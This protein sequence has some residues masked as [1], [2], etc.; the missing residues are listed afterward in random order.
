[1]GREGQL[2]CE[3]CQADAP[4]TKLFIVFGT[5]SI[6]GASVKQQ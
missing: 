2:A 1:M 6:V 5:E 4:K 3:E